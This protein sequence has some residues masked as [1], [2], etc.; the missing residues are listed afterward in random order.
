MSF[1]SK[2]FLSPDALISL[3]HPPQTPPHSY[4]PTIGVGLKP[5]KPR[6]PKPPPYRRQ[7]VQ[8][9]PRAATVLLISLSLPAGG[10]GE[11]AD[12]LGPGGVHSDV[13]GGEVKSAMCKYPHKMCRALLKPDTQCTFG[14]L[15]TEVIFNNSLE[16]Q[17]DLLIRLPFSE[18]P[19]S[20][21]PSLTGP[22]CQ[23][24]PGVFELTIEAWHINKPR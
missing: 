1:C 21:S 15:N 8:P 14:S 19:S 16:Q 4:F 2:R 17:G 6:L 3:S 20:P 18:V 9:S 22:P 7:E 11:G 10:Q 23:A 5:P 24:W 13:E 12:L